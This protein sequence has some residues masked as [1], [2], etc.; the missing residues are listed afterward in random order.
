MIEFY[1]TGAGRI[2]FDQQVPRC[3]KALERIA[4]GLTKRERQSPRPAHRSTTPEQTG[5]TPPA[6]TASSR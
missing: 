3:I 4:D 2:F 1:R 6:R 5:P